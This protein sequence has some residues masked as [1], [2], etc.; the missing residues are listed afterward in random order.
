MGWKIYFGI[1]AVLTVLGL[2]QLLQPEKMTLLD[3][4]HWPVD[5]VA[6]VGLFGYAFHKQM[7]TP[8]TWRVIGGAVVVLLFLGLGQMWTASK[9]IPMAGNPIVMAGAVGV[10]LLLT[11]PMALALFRYADRLADASETATA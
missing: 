6:L 9:D 8:W 2:G 3:W 4:A 7:L 5:V 11:V 1:M 10:I